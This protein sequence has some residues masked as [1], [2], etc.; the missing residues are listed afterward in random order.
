MI[1]KVLLW[2]QWLVRVTAFHRTKIKLQLMFKSMSA[3]NLGK[4]SKKALQKIKKEIK[5][6]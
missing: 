6:H 3:K 1:Q 4:I 5:E 2:Q